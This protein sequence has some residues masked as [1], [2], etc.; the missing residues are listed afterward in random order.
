MSCPVPSQSRHW[1]WAVALLLIVSQSL[2]AEEAAGVAHIRM[3]GTL[4]ESAPSSDPLFGS[5][6][7]LNERLERIRRAAADPKVHALYLHWENPR[8]GW[9]R[10]HEL[11]QAI[12]DFRKSGKKCFAYLEEGS[13]LD[14]LGACAC[15]EVIM[16]PG[17]MLLLCGV[18][19]EMFFYKELLDKLGIKADMM[20]MGAFKGAAEPFTRTRMSPENRQQWEAI[21]DTHY[22]Y[23]TEA[24]ARGRP[25]QN[26]TPADVAKLLDQ[27]PFTARRALQAGLI[28][29]LAYAEELSQV[30]AK[31][32]GVSQVRVT[33][34]YA[35]KKTAE[36][37]WANPFA[38]FRLLAASREPK[39][40]DKPKIAVIF[41]T[42][43]I[44]TG[45]GGMSLF[46]EETIGSTSMVATLRQAIQE[47]TVK[48]IVLRVD[49]PG[50]SAI[51]SDLIWR[52]IYHCPKPVVA[53]MADVAGSGGYYI[54]MGANKIYAEPA[55]LTGSIGVV[56]GKIILGGLFEKIG[57]HSESLS[58]GAHAGVFSLTS[59]FSDSE[60]KVIL[61][62]MQETYDEFLDKALLGRK[63]AGR[64]MTREQLDKFAQGRI[65][66]GVQAK[67]IGL[68]DEIGTLQDA[69]AE[70]RKLAGF[71]PDESVEY[72]YLPKKRAFFETLLESVRDVQ[73]RL[74]DM[75]SALL[76]QPELA[77]HLRAIGVLW[78]L[79][80][81][82]LWL[83]APMGMCI[84]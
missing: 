28:D 16:P 2:W 64:P 36:V 54:C 31:S 65:W 55:T 66:S 30:L 46:G 50:G 84:E 34:N 29:R 40:S 68:V 59:P 14:Y 23:L 37:D 48:A 27:G 9:G 82:R 33:K 7:T 41:A 80:H 67:D 47:P 13:A 19:M 42:G 77:Q 60:R 56:G 72:W 32:L 78:H 8:L 1:F 79:R 26:W 63:K 15:D 70:A 43:A 61:A 73:V 44:V 53:S 20:Q 75:P 25:K 17:G 51:A 24:I 76:K 4:D 39:L 38:L 10:I 74:P 18:R 83:I 22:R 12:Q 62:L 21:L 57:I 6:E 69:I 3:S 81:E 5:S 11:R 49:S 45:K 71:K 52:E 35:K 58:R